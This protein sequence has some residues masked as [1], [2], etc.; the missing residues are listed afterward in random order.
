VIVQI[1]SATYLRHPT[2]EDLERL[3]TVGTKKG[4]PGMLGSLD[5]MHWQWKNC[6]TG[7]VGQF[8]GKCQLATILEPTNKSN[9]KKYKKI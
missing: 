5:C 7:W 6:P 3:L 8:Q 9:K 1:F 4:F 2:V